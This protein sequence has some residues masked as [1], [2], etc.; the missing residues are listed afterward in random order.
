MPFGQHLKQALRLPGLPENSDFHEPTF[1]E[2]WP[3][4]ARSSAYSVGPRRGVSLNARLLVDEF[5]KCFDGTFLWNDR[6]CHQLNIL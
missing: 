1:K 2:H 5:P 4:T 6:V 3:V